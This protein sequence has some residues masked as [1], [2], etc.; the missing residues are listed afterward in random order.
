MREVITMLGFV[1][2]LITAAVLVL[3]AA[4]LGCTTIYDL[5]VW[6]RREKQE[7]PNLWRLPNNISKMGRWCSFE[8]PIVG[9]IEEYLLTQATGVG[10]EDIAAFRERMRQKY[11]KRVE[12]PVDPVGMPVEENK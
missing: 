8:F 10:A 6:K 11:G 3:W 7:Y 12:T 2:G 4:L 9:D 1:V 5:F